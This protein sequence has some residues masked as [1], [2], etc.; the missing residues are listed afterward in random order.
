MLMSFLTRNP[1]LTYKIHILHYRHVEVSLRSF[2]KTTSLASY[3]QD[4][5][6]MANLYLR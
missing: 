5:L 1:G 3:K 2:E 6:L 4:L